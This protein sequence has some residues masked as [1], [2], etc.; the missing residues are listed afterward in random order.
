MSFVL[1]WALSCPPPGH[2]ARLRARRL[3]A[4]RV[5]GRRDAD[6]PAP[7]EETERLTGLD[8]DLQRP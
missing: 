8:A 4:D 1:G 6:A 2:A 5:C 3:V 7:A